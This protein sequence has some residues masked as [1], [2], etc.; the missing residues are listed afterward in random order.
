MA[1]LRWRIV[2]GLLWL[3]TLAAYSI[4][5]ARADGEVFVGWSFTMPFSVTY[6]IGLLIG[7]VVLAT[8]WKP[9]AG[10]I[11]AGVLMMLGLAGAV[12]GLGIAAALGA[13]VGKEISTEAGMGFAFLAIVV[14]IIGGAIVGKKMAVKG[15]RTP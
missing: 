14:Y 1:G 8:G 13:F 9:I 5:W 4:P 12:V 10:T 6:V 11:V 7:A 15:V 3:L 2:Y